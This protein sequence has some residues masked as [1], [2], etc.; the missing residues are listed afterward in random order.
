MSSRASLRL[1]LLSVVVLTIACGGPEPTPEKPAPVFAYVVNPDAKTVAG[2]SVDQSTGALTPL[3]SAPTTVTGAPVALVID[4]Q[5][6]FA[7]IGMRGQ[8]DVLATYAIDRQTGTLTL[9]PSSALTAPPIAPEQ[10]PGW[11]LG[12][13]R[14]ILSSVVLDPSGRFAYVTFDYYCDLCICGVE[15]WIFTY[16]VDSVT[17]MLTKL[18]FPPLSA[19]KAGHGDVPPVG[20]SVVSVVTGAHLYTTSL[21]VHRGGVEECDVPSDLRGFSIDP[22]SGA[23]RELRGSPFAEGHPNDREGHRGLALRPAGDLLYLARQQDTVQ[24]RVSAATGALTKRSTQSSP[25]GPAA[26]SPAGRL[27]A[28]VGAGVR[29]FEI[30]ADTG[31]LIAATGPNGLVATPGLVSAIAIDSSGRY[32]YAV[33]AAAGVVSAFTIDA[34]TGELR[35]AAGAPTAVGVESAAV[36]DFR[37]VAI[38]N[39]P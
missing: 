11:N 16:A 30:Q 37:T 6:R 17:G 15:A 26:F 13:E 2:F 18:V 12:S 14:L 31:D 33:Q 32:L 10:R 21:G 28:A 5:A 20:V 9:V 36:S 7:Y 27:Y 3:T 24:F 34:A 25:I 22:S 8:P 39:V 38:A 35:S 23:L 4:S 19:G 29:A 1:S